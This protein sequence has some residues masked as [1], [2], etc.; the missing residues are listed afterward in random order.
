MR[1]LVP[2]AEKT[3]LRKVVAD[4]EAQ[5]WEGA[6]LTLFTRAAVQIAVRD[7]EA[8][9]MEADVIREAQRL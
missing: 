7:A 4:L 2:P 6:N 5:G 1:W 9:G 3:A 8:R